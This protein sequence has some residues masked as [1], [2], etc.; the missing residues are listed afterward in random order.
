ML[1][2]LKSSIRELAKIID[3]ENSGILF[4]FYTY[5]KTKSRT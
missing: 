1:L 2:I 4:N 3:Q 5:L